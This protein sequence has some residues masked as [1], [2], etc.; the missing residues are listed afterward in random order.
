VS[1]GKRRAPGEGSIYR[2]PKDGRWIVTFQLGYGPSGKRLRRT[3]VTMT[4]AEAARRLAAFRAD[5]KA[6]LDPDVTAWTLEHWLAQWL[7]TSAADTLRP[8]TLATY[9]V[10]LRKHVIPALGG[11]RLRKLRAEDIEAYIRTRLEAEAKPQTIKNEFT[12]LR[13][14]LEVAMRRGYVE[15]NVARLV[16]APKVVREEISPLTPEEVRKFLDTAKGHRFEALFVLAASTGLRR[17]EVLGLTWKAVDLEAGTIRVERALVRHNRAFHLA[18]PK[19]LRS[20][21]SVAIPGPVV[22]LL[23]SHRDRQACQRE[24]VRHAWLNEWDLVFTG[25]AGEPIEARSLHAEFV[26][27][28]ARAEVRRIRFHDLRHGAATVM[29]LRGVPMKVVQEVLGHSQMAMTSDLY[30]HVL[31]ELRRDAADQMEA[32]LFG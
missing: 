21:R 15:R 29:L 6:G 18:E 27:L 17:G 30:S 23:R 7:D 28:L 8:R 16:S 19:T 5:L 24:E 13:R 10:S 22:E 1:E 4:K 26:A 2:R 25:Q 14:A 3:A 20:R 9:R 32:V 11:H 31:P 12:V